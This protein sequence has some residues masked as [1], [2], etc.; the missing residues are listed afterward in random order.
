MSI[1]AF[2]P[3]VEVAGGDGRIS[4]LSAHMDVA[5]ALSALDVASAVALLEVTISIL[6][7]GSMVEGSVH[8]RFGDLVDGKSTGDSAT[9]FDGADEDV[10]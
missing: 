10:F 3:V 5:A 2:N 1:S 9:S 4:R 8:R 6:P 7:L